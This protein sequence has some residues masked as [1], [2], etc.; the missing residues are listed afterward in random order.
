MVFSKVITNDNLGVKK[1]CINEKKVLGRIL[2]ILSRILRILGIKKITGTLRF[3]IHG[4]C[5]GVD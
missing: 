2:Y 1:Y 5:R 4:V 3:F